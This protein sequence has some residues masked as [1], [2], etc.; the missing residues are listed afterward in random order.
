VVP[1]TGPENALVA[2]LLEA[3]SELAR[4]SPDP[5]QL[6]AQWRELR[7]EFTR[8]RL[9]YQFGIEEVLTKVNILRRSSRT[10][11]PTARSSTSARG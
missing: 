5:D 10:P 3:T 9:Y 7:E 1:A 11:T 6:A 4:S 8:F 2:R